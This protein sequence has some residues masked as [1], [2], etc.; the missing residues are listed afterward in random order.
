MQ[1]REP[2]CIFCRIV[3]GEAPS[4]KVH[5]DGTTLTFLDIFPVSPGHTLVITKDH[6]ANVFEATPEA[7][8]A[9]MNRAHATAQ[10]IRRA[11]RP[12]GLAVVQLNG[13]AAGQTVFHYH[14][15]LLPR[16]TGEPFT[17]HGRVRADDAAL[18][19]TAGEIAAALDDA[20]DAR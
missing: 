8:A 13:A 5:E 16:R 14:M 6:F 18:S 3:A 7:L 20:S 9:V 12:D 15:H 2:D 11:L 10:A 19:L 1:Q 17:L 4:A